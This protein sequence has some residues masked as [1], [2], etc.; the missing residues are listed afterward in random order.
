MAY[1]VTIPLHANH[2]WTGRWEYSECWQSL[3]PGQTN[4]NIYIMK[5]KPGRRN[6]IVNINIDGYQSLERIQGIGKVVGNSLNIY[7]SKQ[8]KGHLSPL[9]KSRC[10]LLE[11]RK[12]EQGILT[13]W[14]EITPTLD[15]HLQP[16]VYFVQDH[17]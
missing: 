10:L 15:E 2:P 8:R 6:L 9:Y 5:I 12:T 11:L 4:C 17:K 7:F 14:K 16:G 3:N 13:I 1:L